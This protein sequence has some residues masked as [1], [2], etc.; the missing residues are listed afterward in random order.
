MAENLLAKKEYRGMVSSSLFRGLVVVAWLFYFLGLFNGI[1]YFQENTETR[2]HAQEESYKQWLNQE[3]KGPHS[4]AHY[5]L[6]AFKPVPA[7]S[8]MDKGME[9]F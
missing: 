2:T 7:L 4:A 9:D 5:G 1:S 6:Y 8:I 3:D